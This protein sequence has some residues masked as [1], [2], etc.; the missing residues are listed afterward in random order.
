VETLES[1]YGQTVSAKAND[2][3]SVAG[4]VAAL[5]AAGVVTVGIYSTSYQWGQITGGSG[6]QFATQP[7]WVAGTG[8]L[9]TAQSNC[10]STSFTGA[11]VLLAQ[12]ARNGY[13]A[14]VHC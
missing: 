14:D 11:P 8:S 9:S 10:R 3:A 13:D 12:Y 4:A 7:A 1:A 2:R 5:Q 6:T